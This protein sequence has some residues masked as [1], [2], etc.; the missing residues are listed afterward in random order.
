MKEFFRF[1]LKASPFVAGLLLVLTALAFLVSF[2]S[3]PYLEYMD[4]EDYITFVLFGFVGLT[5][6]LWGAERLAGDR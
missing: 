4:N 2:S 1:A 3:R 6:L 5:M